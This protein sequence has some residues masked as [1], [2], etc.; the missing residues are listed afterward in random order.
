MGVAAIFGPQSK[1]SSS[2][3]QS[4]CDAMEIPHVSASM[5]PYAERLK[6]I[7]MHPHVKTLSMV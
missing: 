4:M 5:E 1:A 3:V 2:H 7:N 6:A